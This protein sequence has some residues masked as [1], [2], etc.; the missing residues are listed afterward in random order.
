MPG[1]RI[2]NDMMPPISIEAERVFEILGFPISNSIIASW[3]TMLI[4]IVVSVLVSRNTKLA[5]AARSFQNIVEAVL[6]M[7]YNGVAKVRAGDQVRLFFPLSATIFFFVLT[8]NWLGALIPGFGSIGLLEHHH[9]EEVFVPLLRSTCSDL[10]TTLALALFAVISIQIYGVKV[11]GFSRYAGRFIRLGGFLNFFKSLVGSQP[12][13]GMIKTLMNAVID[14]FI[15]V[16]EIFDEL[17]KLLSFSFRLFGNI[18]AGEV[19]LIVIALLVPF[20]APLP[21]QGLELFVGYIQALIFSTLTL[22]FLKM[23]TTHH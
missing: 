16:L 6:E 9:G 15:G 4:L 10:N 22:V 7:F 17:T 13:K 11:Q 14:A 8:S 2:V 20:I 18:F 3:L 1:I 12:R 23:A 19:L 21:F 5:P